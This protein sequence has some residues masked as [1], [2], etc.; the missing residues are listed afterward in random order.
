MEHEQGYSP[1]I[2]L[3][4]D[5]LIIEYNYHDGPERPPVIAGLVGRLHNGVKSPALPGGSFSHSSSL[6]RPGSANAPGDATSTRE[7]SPSHVTGSGLHEG[8][9]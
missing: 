1:N 8:G 7:T 4:S 6:P 2:W 9:E 5:T 3:S